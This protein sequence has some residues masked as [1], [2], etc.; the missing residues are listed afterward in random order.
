MNLEHVKQNT[1]R[2]FWHMERMQD[3]ELTSKVNDSTSKRVGARNRVEEDWKE[4]NGER[5]HGMVYA[6]EAWKD[7]DKHKLFGCGN[8]FDGNSQRERAL[9]I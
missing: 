7:K 6:R 4:R 5:M 3:R 9:E 8:P 1:L 2:W